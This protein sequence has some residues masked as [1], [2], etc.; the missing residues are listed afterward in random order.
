MAINYDD[1]IQFF[2]NNND[3]SEHKYLANLPDRCPVCSF[4][5]SPNYILVYEKTWA[6]QELICGC[7]RYECGA[8]FIAEYSGAG[9]WFDIVRCY[10]SSKVNKEFP[11]EVSDLTPDFVAIYNQANHAE[12]EGLDLICGVAYRKALE[13]L[14]K[15][16]V[17]KIYPDDDS[18]IKSIPLQQC[19]QK[20]ISEPSIKL[21]AERA[22]W[23]GNDETHYVRKW[24]DKDLRDLK[25]LIDLT[26]YFISMSLKALTYQEEMVA[27]KK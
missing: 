27:G 19:I 3:I 2:D 12:Q 18:K 15:D 11:Q 13:Y 16:Y 8:L 7:P 25:N 4:S 24:E 20:F 22:T 5:I 10:P 9:S 17:L 6:T 23:L 26:V 21:M 1:K 14:I